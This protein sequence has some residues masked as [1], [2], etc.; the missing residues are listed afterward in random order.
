[1]DPNSTVDTS[2]LKFENLQDCNSGTST[3]ISSPLLLQSVLTSLSTELTGTSHREIK[4]NFNGVD[5]HVGRS[6]PGY[7]FI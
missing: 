5:N 1:M 7:G 4:F 3:I 2:S 6:T